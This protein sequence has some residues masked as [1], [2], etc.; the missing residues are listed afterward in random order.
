MRNRITHKYFGI[1]LE[2]VWGVVERDLPTLKE[3]VLKMMEELPE[4]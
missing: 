3:N 1:I 2:R 4:A